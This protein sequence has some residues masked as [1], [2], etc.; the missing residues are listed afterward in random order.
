[1]PKKY[2]KKRGASCLN[3]QRIKR[4][5]DALSIGVPLDVACSLADVDDSTVNRA[6]RKNRPLCAAIKGANGKLIQGLTSIILPAAK[7]GQWQAAAWLLERRYP[8][9][10]ARTERQEISGSG[11][12]PLTPDRA[13]WVMA[14]REALGFVDHRRKRTEGNHEGPVPAETQ[15]GGTDS[16]AADKGWRSDSLANSSESRD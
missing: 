1:M 6:R 10:F 13:G 8:E 2:S 4:I 9:S 14:V 7:N 12:A 5:C 16:A 15:A 11:G 3:L